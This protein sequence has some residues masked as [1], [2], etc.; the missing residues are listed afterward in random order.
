VRETRRYLL[1][2]AL[3]LGV[4]ACIWLTLVSWQV[5]SATD[6]SRWLSDIMRAKMA[7]ANA[8]QRP[9]LLVAGGSA[10]LFGIS[11]QQIEVGTGLP[12]INMAT[13]AGLGIGYMLHMIR[14]AAK[15]GDT[16]LLIL[17]YE[18]YD[19]VPSDVLVDYLYA[20]D[21]GYIASLPLSL[22]WKMPLYLSLPRLL[23]GLTSRPGT[24]GVSS[25]TTF[26]C[27]NVRSLNPQG[28]ETC[29][30]GDGRPPEALARLRE[31]IASVP[32][33]SPVIA[34]E[35]L[36]EIRRFLDWCRATN[37]RV[38]VS[39]P[40][41]VRTP[42]LDNP[43]WMAF[44]ARVIGFY[45]SL[46]L[47]VLGSPHS[48]M[49]DQSLFYDTRYHLNDRGVQLRTAQLIGLLMGQLAP[50]DPRGHEAHF[51]QKGMPKNGQH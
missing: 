3:G 41:T 2:L 43:S 12:T 45:R 14:Q 22:R 31:Q 50:Q 25:E 16:I 9:K 27:Y 6:D 49:Y 15:P 18:I 35:S 11:G 38:I 34:A 40:N 48:F 44:F 23:N 13:H 37:V 20:R 28:D 46:D 1:G 4:A 33:N 17:E 30:Q 39:F 36:Q 19:A 10:S 32:A 42:V 5:G 21:P 24:A 26:G 47:P 29:N 51:K 8:Q 7:A